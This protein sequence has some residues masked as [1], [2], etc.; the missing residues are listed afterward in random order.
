[1]LA[2][3]SRTDQSWQ[4][5][6]LRLDS[7]RFEYTTIF[8]ELMIT[9]DQQRTIR[10]RARACACIAESL[11]MIRQYRASNP[12]RNDS[13]TLTHQRHQRHAA[14]TLPTVR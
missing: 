3:N 9:D 6:K 12:A 10:L 4:E 11:T 2:S 1:M 14:R 7:L 13:V 5:T 8:E